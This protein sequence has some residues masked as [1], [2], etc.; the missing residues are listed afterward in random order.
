MKGARGARNAAA[1]F[2]TSLHIGGKALGREKIG[3]RIA[4]F[5]SAI[6]RAQKL[7]EEE[8]KMMYH[9]SISKLSHYKLDKKKTLVLFLSKKLFCITK[10]RLYSIRMLLL[11]RNANANLW[12]A[13]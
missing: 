10:R 11:T 5:T 8:K 6:R 4:H 3:T 2:A 7:L 13:N 12:I 9:E 1:N